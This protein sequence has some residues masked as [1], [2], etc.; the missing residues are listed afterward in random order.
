MFLQ[1]LYDIKRTFRFVN[2]QIRRVHESY[3]IWLERLQIQQ[4]NKQRQDH[5]KLW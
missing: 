1:K 2:Y 5:K 4:L 3:Y